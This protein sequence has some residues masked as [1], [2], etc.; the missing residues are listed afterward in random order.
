MHLP[1]GV[2]ALLAVLLLLLILGLAALAVVQYRWIDRVSDAE[3]QRMRANIDFAARRFSEDVR[4]ELEGLFEAFARPEGPDLAQ[5][6][7]TWTRNAQHPRLLANLY[8]IERGEDAQFL[9]R[10]DRDSGELVD[11][12]WPPWLP[13]MGREPPP[14]FLGEVPAMFIAPRRGGMPFGEMPPRAIAIELDRA[15]LR[16]VLLPRLATQHFSTGTDSYA[17]AILHG[18]EV[19]YRSDASWPD[20]RTPPDFESRFLPIDPARRGGP[21]AERRREGGMPRF[22]REIEPWRLVVRRRD[23]GL[24]ALVASARRRNLALSFGILSILAATML[25]LLALL[26]RADR[27]RAQQT[28]FVAAMTHELNTPIAALRAAGENLKDGIVGDGEKLTRYGETI[29]RESARLGEMVAQVLDFAGIQ[30]RTSRTPDEPVDLRAVVDE[31]VA[32]CRWLVDG[33]ATGS[34][35]DV[36]TNVGADLPLVRGDAQA[37]TRAIQNLVANA[38]R[39]GGAGQWVGVTASRNGN[40]VAIAVEDRGPGIDGRDAAHLFEP[41]YRGRNSGRVRGAGLGL[42]IVQQIARAH[43]GSVDVDRRRGGGA[44][45]TLHLP[46]A[47]DRV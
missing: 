7:E 17:I 14:P 36:E 18:N 39:H 37:L 44:A 15:E 20:G 34:A 3:R 28:Q 31:A 1:R 4:A 47:V 23:G 38:I 9:R 43:G 30:A 24:E 6:Y 10:L 21:G 12:E 29:V 5:R 40:G 13:D 27:L 32:Q 11:A 45:F 2:N 26:R 42:A 22:G 46:A 19:L 33:S 35:I 25:V 41:F 16:N 8:V